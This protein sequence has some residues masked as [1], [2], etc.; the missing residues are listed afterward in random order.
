MAT[1]IRLAE[2]SDAAY[3]QAI[4]ATSVRDT[5]ISFELEPPT[6]DE[7]R[8]RISSTLERFPWLVCEA[9]G[10]VLGYAYAS[11]HRSRLAYQ[12]SVD[13]SVYIDPSTHRH[14]LGRAVYASLF[15]ILKLQGFANAYAGITLPNP[16]SVGLHESMGFERVGVYRE[17]GYKAGAWHDVGW[18]YLKLGM[19]ALAPEPP[20][21]LD[22]AMAL[23]G[24][25]EA[26]NTGA[27]TLH[28]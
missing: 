22:E 5:A 16:A 24:W 13:V 17:V 27:K 3:V 1:T 25:D 18:W 28:A 23:P 20:L 19:H 21:T 14:G 12:W 8:G 26:L 4:Y 10:A 7:M 11:S 9:D 2:E 15:G 6:V